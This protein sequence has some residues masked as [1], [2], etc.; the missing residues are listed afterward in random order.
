MVAFVLVIRGFGFV[1]FQD[2]AAVE[3]V[4]ASKPHMLGGK[5]VSIMM[6]GVFYLWVHVMY[7][8]L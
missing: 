5:T 3:Q 4:L 8:C 6:L 1:T 7:G 2:P